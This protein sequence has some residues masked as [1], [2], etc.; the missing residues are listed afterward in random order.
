MR[1]RRPA[2]A[3]VRPP[4]ARQIAG[5]ATATSLVGARSSQARDHRPRSTGRCW[6]SAYFASTRC[7]RRRTAVVD[8]TVGRMA[9]PSI[10]RSPRARSR[11]GSARAGGTSRCSGR[12]QLHPGSTRRARRWPL[13]RDTAGPS[14]TC[15]RCDEHGDPR[16]L[17]AGDRRAS[18]R[19]R[20]VPADR[21]RS[22][23]QA[24]AW[25]CAGNAGGRISRRSTG[26][27]TR[28]VGDLLRLELLS[29]GGHSALALG[30]PRHDEL[31][32]R[33]RLV[34][35]RADVAARTGGGEGMAAAAARAREDALARV[36]VT[37]ELERRQILRWRRLGHRPDDR[38]GRGAVSVPSR[39]PAARS[40]SASAS[41]RAKTCVRRIA[42]SL[43]SGVVIC[44]R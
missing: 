33:L 9:E 39:Q 15:A 44:V 6:K 36:G 26:R 35:V 31:V 20:T 4:A 34:E 29:E 42:A 14:G 8:V 38:V 12:R 7:A 25:T 43:T 2:K 24:N 30:D 28:D 23:S 27:R 17:G 41:S 40:P 5:S 22:R 19:R 18:P 13:P 3:S 37:V 16:C 32:A 1:K 11:A 10:T 21:V